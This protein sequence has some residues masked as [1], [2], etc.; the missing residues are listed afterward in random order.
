MIF[1]FTGTGNSLAAAKALA[2][3]QE[4]LINLADANR[5]KAYRY[6]VEK[7]GRIGFVFPE[8]CSTLCKPVL[9]FV[10]NLEV[11]GNPY[12]FAVITCG[13]VI[14][15]AAGMLRHELAQRG[16]RLCYAA[17]VRMPN[18][19][20][21]YSE[22]PDDAKQT[23][24]LRKADTKL[25]ALKEKLKAHPVRAVRGGLLA[26]KSQPILIKSSKT[27]PFR[28]EASC[29]GCGACAKRCPEQAIR[30]EN[31]KPVWV[32]DSCAICMACIS[33]CPVGAIEYGDKTAGRRR[34]VHPSLR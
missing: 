25:A 32:K 31:G 1:Y 34:Y 5:E 26:E 18:N 4:P 13:G 10:R 20:V 33:R 9:E 27:A 19:A 14:S 8:Y 29:T 6:T 15:F 11:K 22:T 21:F 2:E 16:I 12:C 28:A 24:L 3:E 23:R 7:G 17:F 30:M